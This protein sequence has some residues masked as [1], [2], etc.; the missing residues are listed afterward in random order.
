[1]A[2]YIPGVTPDR[3][4]GPDLLLRALNW[5]IIVGWLLM[6]MALILA[7]LAKP[8]TQT[9]FDRLVHI[10]PKTTWDVRL[11][12]YI[13]YIMIL[14]LLISVVGLFINLKRNR[15]KEDELRVS[16]ILIG[17]MSIIGMLIYFMLF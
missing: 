8:Q 11:V 15:R 5:F 4:K 7:S 1:M 16:F 10:T 2:E 6:F 17:M 12:T 3:R 14:G 9:F 13:L